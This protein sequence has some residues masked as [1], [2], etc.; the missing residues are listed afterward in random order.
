MGEAQWKFYVMFI[1][2]T[3]GDVTILRPSLVEKGVDFFV[4]SEYSSEDLREN[5]EVGVQVVGVSPLLY[6]KIK[7]VFS[8]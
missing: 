7:D 1:L 5:G 8:F 4:S 6:F 2:V 3:Y